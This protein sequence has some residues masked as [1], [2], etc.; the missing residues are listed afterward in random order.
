MERLSQTELKKRAKKLYFDRNSKIDTIFVD[1]FGRFSYTPENL[2]MINKGKDVKIIPIN[3]KDCAK[4]ST[5]G[6]TDLAD[7][8]KKAQE[9]KKKEDKKTETKDDKK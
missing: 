4:V 5:E 9:A 6:I 7:E 3:R 2:K 1:E 8:S